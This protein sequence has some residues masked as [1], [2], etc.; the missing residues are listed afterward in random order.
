MIMQ[1]NTEPRT[2]GFSFSNTSVSEQRDWRHNAMSQI[3]RCA[4]EDG[5]P[6]HALFEQLRENAPGVAA[7]TFYQDRSDVRRTL[8][9]VCTARAIVESPLEHTDDTADFIEPRPVYGW[10]EL[11]LPETDETIELVALP[12]LGDSGYFV[13]FGDS[14]DTCRV[15][16]ERLHKEMHAVHHRCR[17]FLGTWKDDPELDSEAS[18][19]S[20]DDIV[21]A[22]ELLNDIRRTI[23][24]FFTS[25]E[26]FRT[27]GFPWR[28]GILLIGPPGTGKTM[29]CKAAAAAH[30]EVPF[31]YVGDVRHNGSLQQIFK[32]ARESA[33]CI[34]AFEDMDGL[35]SDANRTYFLNELDGFRNN[36]GIL[37]I[38]SSNHPKRIDEALLKRPSRFDRVYHI[39]LPAKAERAEYCRRFLAKLPNLAAGF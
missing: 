39:G 26:A 24:Q 3:L 31:L 28:R 22:P 8:P 16:I 4:S 37:I 7:H 6:I 29:V 5:T 18:K 21:L 1:L 25:K 14:S 35:V 38:A 30:P 9:R 12:F 27:I 17:R 10:W 33:P 13:V 34:L 19:V 2:N 20:W 23:D 36:D 15:F 11:T 32:H